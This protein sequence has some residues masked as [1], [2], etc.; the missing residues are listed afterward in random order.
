M[1]IEFVPY[2]SFRTVCQDWNAEIKKI[3][4]KAANI[5][6]VWYNLKKSS[7]TES[8]D[9]GTVPEL[10]RHYV[11]HYPNEYFMVYPEFTV[12]KLHLPPIVLA[13]LPPLD[14][15]KRSDVRDWMMNIPLTLNEWKYVGW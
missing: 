15:R 10:V 13:V 4:K 12:S 9:S 7:F 1:I 14:H 11:L 2:S 5:I 3:Q 8:E 6:S